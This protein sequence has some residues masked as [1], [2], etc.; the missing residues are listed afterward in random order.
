MSNPKADA[1]IAKLDNWKNE[2]AKLRE[3][4]LGCAPL[5]ENFK[6]G[7]PCYSLDSGNVVLIHGF[8]SFCTLR[9]YH[10]SKIRLYHT[11]GTS[12]GFTAS[13]RRAYAFMKRHGYPSKLWRRPLPLAAMRQ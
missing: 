5:T 3:I 13:W 8:A 6:W 2:L 11:S 9:L 10:T 1:Y 12:R 4:A 7:H